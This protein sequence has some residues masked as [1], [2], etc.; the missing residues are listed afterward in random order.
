MRSRACWETV[1]MR[2]GMTKVALIVETD[3]IQ[4]SKADGFDAEEFQS[5]KDAVQNYV[6]SQSHIDMVV[7][8]K[9]GDH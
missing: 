8:Y 6:A 2:G 7:F 9:I 5:L 3:L 4:D 1:G